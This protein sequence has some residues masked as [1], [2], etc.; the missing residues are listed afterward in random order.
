MKKLFAIIWLLAAPNLLSMH[1]IPPELNE[2]QTIQDFA[3]FGALIADMYSVE[4]GTVDVALFNPPFK[5]P[6]LLAISRF[7]AKTQDTAATMFLPDGRLIIG[8]TKE[9]PLPKEN[10]PQ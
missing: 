7:I 9:S 1:G 8:L 3:R 10:T 6:T 4:D 5:G 2:P